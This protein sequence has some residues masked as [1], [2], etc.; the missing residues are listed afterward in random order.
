[1]ADDV[2]YW[3]VGAYSHG[4]M[5]PTPNIDRIAREG[6]LFT[7]HYAQP[8]C[9][10]GRAAFITGQLPIRTGLTTVGHG[11]L[12][13]RARRPRSDAGRGAQAAGLPHRAVRQEPPGRPQRAPAHGPRLRRVLRQP[14]PPQHR[15]GAGAAGVAE[16]R[17]ASTSATVRAAC[18]TRW[19]PTSTTRRWT[20]G[21]GASARQRIN[22]TG[23]ADHQAHG[24][25]RRG[26]RR[27]HQGLHPRVGEAGQAVLRLAQP[28]PDAHLHAPEAASHATWRR[29]TPR[30][31][32]S[33]A[34]A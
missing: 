7:D 4:M 25:G 31:S 1:M 14:L 8:S 6:I 33:T 10:P 22:D 32:T 9:T 15:G 29:R 20:R 28:E 3:N 5:V 12:A 24:D 21:S 13:D 27:A 16:G 11:R 2:G 26:V 17:R 34:A 23:P 18:S 19:R 30:R